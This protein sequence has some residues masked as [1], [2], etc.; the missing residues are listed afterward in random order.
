MIGYLYTLQSDRPGK[1]CVFLYYFLLFLL[2]VLLEFT[3]ETV[4]AWRFVFYRVFNYGFVVSNHY[5]TI[6]IFCFITTEL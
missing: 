5:S 1:S 2:E 3:S 4:W 6:P